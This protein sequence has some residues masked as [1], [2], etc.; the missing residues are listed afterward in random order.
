MKTAE[1]QK[2]CPNCDGRIAVELSQCPYCFA[3]LAAGEEQKIENAGYRP[4]YQPQQIDPV[5]AEESK[6]MV[7]E[8]P[9]EIAEQKEKK[10]FWSILALSIGG[11]LATL[12]ILEFL[13]AEKGRV[14]LEINAEYWFLFLLLAFPLLYWGFKKNAK[15]SF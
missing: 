4:L 6:K 7:E 5:A 9:Q 13:F 15:N 14:Y 2:L 1:R 12:G 10:S 11:N 8:E 3:M